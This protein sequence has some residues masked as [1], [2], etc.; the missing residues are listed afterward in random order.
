MLLEKLYVFKY[1]PLLGQLC[2]IVKQFVQYDQIC[3]EKLLLLMNPHY[4]YFQWFD[5]GLAADKRPISD[6]ITAGVL[7]VLKLCR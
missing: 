2:H 6:W 1:V 3:R 4:P 5:Y 7:P